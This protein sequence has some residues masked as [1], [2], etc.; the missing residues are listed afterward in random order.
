METR[1]AGIE[2]SG[3]RIVGADLGDARVGNIGKAGRAYRFQLAILQF[4]AGYDIVRRRLRQ[5]RQTECNGIGAGS[6]GRRT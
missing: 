1:F 6:N 4:D 3:R 2:D 5:G